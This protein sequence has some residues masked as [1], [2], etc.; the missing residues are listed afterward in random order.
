VFCYRKGEYYLMAKVI[1]DA[2]HGGSDIGESYSNRK[3]KDDNLRLVLRI[4]EILEKKGIEVA[5]TRLTD[6]YLPQ[7]DRV[8]LANNLDA[9]LLISIHRLFG[10]NM[11]KGPGLDFFV[12]NEE[13]LGNEAAED[14][15]KSLLKVGFPNYGTVIRTD[16]SLLSQTNMPA[17][18]V[19]IGYMKSAEEND[20]F[21]ENFEAIAEAIANGIVNALED[22][23]EEEVVATSRSRTSISDS[24]YQ[25]RVQTGIFRTYNN[26]I[27]HQIKLIREGQQ[28]DIV[29]QGECFAVQ[30]G[31]FSK[32]DEA[33]EL[34]HLLRIVGYNTLLVAV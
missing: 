23:D 7:P 2:G 25:Y 11:A 15:G 12:L 6:T 10:E 26:A 31:E 34:E 33:V 19:G 8:L 9:D 20:F 1:L 27:I 22:M 30:V 28:A 14:I 18:M 32:L 13:G 3:E 24:G 4:G 5:Y 29:R 17:I 21:D 16:L